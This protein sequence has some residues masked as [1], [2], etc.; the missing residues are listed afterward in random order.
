MHHQL[1]E[2]HTALLTTGEHFGWLFDVVLAEQQTAKEA[3]H[4]LLV[5]AFRL[6]LAHPV[7]NGQIV[8]EIFGVILRVITNLRILGPF[9]GAVIR[10]QFT[11]QRFQHGGFTHAVGTEDSDLLAHF[12]QQV[13]VLEQRAVVETFGQLFDG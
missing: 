2:Q 12:Q 7:E 11:H 8:V 9:H 5:I 3:A 4:H 13:E 6:P 1:A 10:S